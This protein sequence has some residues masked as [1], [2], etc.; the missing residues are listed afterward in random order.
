MRRYRPCE[1]RPRR[2]QNVTLRG[3]SMRHQKRR[4]RLDARR[5]ATACKGPLRN[6]VW[7][8]WLLSACFPQARRLTRRGS[9]SRPL[10]EGLG[11]DQRK[12]ADVVRSESRQGLQSPLPRME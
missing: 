12:T 7:A 3:L 6:S 10:G 5:P 1:M 11:E 2:P 9:S 8:S 4:F